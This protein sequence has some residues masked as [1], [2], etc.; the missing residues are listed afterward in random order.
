MLATAKR[1]KTAQP[2][3][4]HQMRLEMSGYDGV[5]FFPPP[6]CGVSF[7][8][9]AMRK[10]AT[11][12]GMHVRVYNTAGP[13]LDTSNITRAKRCFKALEALASFICRSSRTRPV[14]MSA[15]GGYALL[16]EA[17][18]A[19]VARFAGAP[20]F[21]HH[22]SFRYI[23]KSFWPMRL[24]R[25]ASGQDATHVMLSESM[26]RRFTA[27]YGPVRYMCVSNCAFLHAPSADITTSSQ[28]TWNVGHFS[29]LSVEKGLK[30][31]I[32]L[33]E[34]ARNEGRPWQFWIA[35]P[36]ASQQVELQYRPR[37]EELPNVK[38]L[39][40]LLEEAKRD[41]YSSL[42]VFVM[43]TRYLNEA[44]PIVVLEA[45]Q[46]GVP[47]IAYDRGV[48]LE[49]LQSCGVVIRDDQQ[50][51]AAAS[52]IIARWHSD[53]GEHKQARAAT[54]RA[55]QALFDTSS[56]QRDKLLGLLGDKQIGRACVPF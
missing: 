2:A 11:A 7:V 6:W 39:G 5:G 9:E 50:F 16:Y 38:L 54:L 26:A 13:A 43:P 40:P 15:S 56:L 37:I 42:D 24:L 12:S 25:K 28:G 52:R 32:A 29:N 51:L 17:C 27:V 1:N 41:F 47:V 8:N 44:E 55:Y 21:I 20:T 4:D 18:F 49:V 46:Y 3:A 22:N 45:M 10:Q 48:L 36:F 53:R 31:V 35:G 14:Y 34:V 33:A 23:N 30:D 19:L